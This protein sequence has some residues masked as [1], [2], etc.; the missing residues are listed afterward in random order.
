ML[1]FV[2]HHEHFCLNFATVTREFSVS[3]FMLHIQWNIENGFT[4]V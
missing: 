2:L 1:F 4:I 3:I